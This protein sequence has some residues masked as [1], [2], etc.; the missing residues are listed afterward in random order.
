MKL[1][2]SLARA[3]RDWLGFLSELANDYGDIAFFRVLHVPACFINRPDYIEAVLG[4]DFRHFFKSKDYV[5][6]KAVMGEGLVTSEGERWRRQR[7]LVQPAFHR[8]RIAAY[9]RIMVE[10]AEKMTATWRDGEM[11]DAHHD[12]TKLTLDIVAKTLFDADVASEAADIGAAIEKAMSR[13]ASI[14]WIS[15]FLPRSMDE[16]GRL[17]FRRTIRRLD[18]IIYGIVRARRESGADTGD[19]LSMLLEAQA[20]DGGRMTD[21]QVR[22]EVMTL[23]LAG[24]E[25]TANALAWTW[26]LLARH[27]EAED[28]LHAELRA[29]L[30]G[31]SPQVEDLPRLRYT[32]MVVKES[33]RLFPPVWGIGRET[34]HEF[35]LGGY[36]L[37]VGTNVFISQWVTQRDPRYFERPAEFSP[38]RWT[39]DF[40]KRLPRFA[41]FP[42]GGGARACIGAS[43][44]TMEAALLL[45]TIAQRF[46]LTLGGGP[47]TPF[48]SATL[49]PARGI[50]VTLRKR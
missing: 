40:E 50:H 32:Q 47:V 48:A 2:V 11:R 29:V 45:A 35:Q 22:D 9:G 17:I 13:F 33:L 5:P 6:L 38:E 49:R 18:D 1:Y 8:E 41:Y 21:R 28:R 26:Y 46:R 10:Y 4:A 27:P 36:R 30:A 42:F 3:P 44:A 31:R 19:L 15:M 34:L 39:D 24:H 7:Q 20:E 43:F 25:T 23:F 37:P 16:P 14:G 12:M